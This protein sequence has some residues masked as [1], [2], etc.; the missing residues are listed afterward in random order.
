MRLTPQ[1]RE[2][3]NQADINSYEPAVEQLCKHAIIRNLAVS[4]RDNYVG[5]AKR[6]FSYLKVYRDGVPFEKTTYDDCR[7]FVLYLITQQMA[8]KTINC[9]ISTMAKLYYCVR[10][11]YFDTSEVPYQKI[12]IHIPH[13]ITPADFCRLYAVC[14]N[15]LEKA[16]IC[17][18][19]C[20]GVRVNEALE[21]RFMDIRRQKHFI[22]IG[23][24]KGRQERLTLIGDNALKELERYYYDLYGKRHVDSTSYIFMK[25]NRNGQLVRLTYEDA[26]L[27]LKRLTESACLQDR[28]YTLHTFRHG[29]AV[30]LYRRTKDPMLLATLL[31]HKHLSATETYVRLAAVNSILDNSIPNP[32]DT[33]LNENKH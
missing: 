20:S 5:Y 31:G 32:L 4:T 28:G 10:H 24:S 18:L 22:Y 25:H 27:I 30:E 33:V 13:A 15:S 8:P 19:F 29:F 3:L 14:S 21:M 2:K 26:R 17:L 16:F 1:E 23:P 6:Y 7:E 9:Y 11:E 12:D